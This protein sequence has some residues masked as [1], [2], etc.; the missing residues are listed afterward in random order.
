MHSMASKANTPASKPAFDHAELS[1]ACV[2][3]LALALIALFLC[4]VPLT[5]K[6]AS[7]RDFVVYWATGQ[8]LA[9]H[10]NPYDSDALM[11]IERAAGLP[12]QYNVLYMRNP[13]WDL[14]LTL[15]LGFIGLRIGALLW[16]LLLAGCLAASVRL[17]WVMHGRPQ[18]RLHWLGYSFAPAMI[19]LFAGQ[20]SLFTLLG[21]VLFL[22][23]HQTRPFIAG[24]SLWLCAL[25][26]HL[27]L[28]F[29]LVLLTWMITSRSYKILAGGVAAIAASSTLVYWIDPMAWTQYFQMIRNSGIQA[30]YIPCLSVALRVWLKPNAMWIPYVPPALGCL[31][32]LS[33]FWARRQVWDWLKHGSPLMLASILLA[34]YCW[35]FDQSVAVPAL[36]H[37]AY[38]TRSRVLLTVLAF[39]SVLID[40]ELVA[41]VKMGSILFL[42]TA[43][44]WLAWYLFADRAENR[45][46]VGQL[47]S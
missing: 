41:N 11:H 38:V 23:F 15:P 2:G 47:Q 26:P 1:I 8:Q 39:I 17:L 46:S 24:F 16:S 21:L 10:A 32:A 4:V 31:W 30:E 33:Y 45:S 5:G 12:T 40:I 43:P 22:R 35:M 19:C 3:G 42:W 29:G 20:T 9:Q 28:P 18:N 6:V 25:K 37:G 44:A 13:P 34:P 14:I 36:L 7:G 27:F